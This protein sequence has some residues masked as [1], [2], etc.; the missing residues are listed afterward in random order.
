MLSYPPPIL[1]FSVDS[2]PLPIGVLAVV[3]RD[4]GEHLQESKFLKCL[5]RID[6]D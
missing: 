4:D 6:R 3:R 5:P 2:L 1:L